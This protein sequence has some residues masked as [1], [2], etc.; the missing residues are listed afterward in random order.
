M[1]PHE[2]VCSGLE[3]REIPCNDAGLSNKVFANQSVINLSAVLS[4]NLCSEIYKKQKLK[5]ERERER[6]RQT[7]TEIYSITNL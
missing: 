1:A 4:L 2:A 7:E 3:S 5:R 6:D